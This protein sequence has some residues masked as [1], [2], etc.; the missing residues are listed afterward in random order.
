VS[1]EPAQSEEKDC[2][3]EIRRKSDGS[4][5]ET[6]K[7][8]A[9]S[10]NQ[11]KRSHRGRN[12]APSTELQIQDSES[13]VL[14]HKI[15]PRFHEQTNVKAFQDGSKQDEPLVLK[16]QSQRPLKESTSALPLEQQ[17]IRQR[18]N[19]LANRMMMGLRNRP[20]V[21]NR[22]TLRKEKP[23]RKVA[24]QDQFHSECTEPSLMFT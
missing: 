19:F 2:L 21:D 9:S 3:P 6:P 24:L 10:L 22:L 5:R 20:Y 12:E 14:D 13:E 7:L 18:T 11:L 15:E 1:A 4:L 23:A 17:I 8:R 16:Q